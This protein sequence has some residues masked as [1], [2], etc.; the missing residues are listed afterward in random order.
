MSVVEASLM[1]ELFWAF[2]CVHGSLVDMDFG[3]TAI[4]GTP[5]SMRE[6]E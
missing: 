5:P 2:V 4:A 1:W 6:Q 3:G